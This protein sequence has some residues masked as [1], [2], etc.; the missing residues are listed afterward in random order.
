M[1]RNLTYGEEF[2]NILQHHPDHLYA[3]TD[4]S[5]DNGRAAYAAVLNKTVLKKVLK[6]NALFSQKPLQ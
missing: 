5:K 2:H 4:G 6:G 3:F 1:E